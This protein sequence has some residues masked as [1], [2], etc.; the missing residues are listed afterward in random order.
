MQAV[1]K[2]NIDLILYVV[3]LVE[4]HEREVRTVQTLAAEEFYKTA[5]CP[6]I[7]LAEKSRN[8]LLNRWLDFALQ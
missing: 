1:K 8:L 6:Q 2:I 5:I 7:S 3:Y 4:C